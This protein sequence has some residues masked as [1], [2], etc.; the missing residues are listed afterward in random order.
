MKKIRMRKWFVRLTGLMAVMLALLAGETVAGA[1]GQN[2]E[3]SELM[4][5]NRCTLKAEDGTFPDWVEL[6]NSSSEEVSLEGLKLTDR[7]NGKNV[8]AFPD[9]RIPPQGRLIVF[10]DGVESSAKELHMPFK[11]S[12]D[13]SIFLLSPDGEVLDELSTAGVQKDASVC[14]DNG[15]IRMSNYPT[16]GFENTADGF[17]AFQE[18]YQ[19]D[20]PLQINEVRV[21]D[22][23]NYYVETEAHYD[24]V[25]LINVSDQPVRMSDYYLSDDQDLLWQYQ[26]PD[27]VL[28]P[29]GITVILCTKEN[30][31]IKPYTGFALNAARERLFLSSARGVEDY[32][33]LHDIPYDA[34]YGRLPGENGFFYL[35]EPTQGQANRGRAGRTVSTPPHAETE[36]GVFDGTLP[37]PLVLGGEGTIYYTTDGSYPTEKSDVYTGPIPVEKTMIVRAVAVQGD[38]LPSAPVT[39]SYFV[40]EHHSLPVISIVSN[41]PRTL[42]DIVN[43]GQKYVEVPGSIAL[44]ENGEPQ[45]RA[46]CGVKVSGQ[47]SRVVF[48][49]RNIKVEFRSV[50][51]NPTLD[52]DLFGTGFKG[53]DS[54]VLR[55][56]QDSAF[57]LFSNEIWQDLCLEMSD[58]VLTQHGKFCIVYLNGSYYGIYALKEN[59]S[60]QYYAD[61]AGVDPITVESEI[62][63]DNNSSDYLEMYDLIRNGDMSD[64]E[65]Y[66]RA[67]RMLD[68]DSFID[69]SIMEGLCG[70]FDLFLNVRFFRSSENGD[71]YQMALF[72]LD[73]SMRNGYAT[74][75]C[76]MFKEGYCGMP[77][78]NATNI[79][80]GL[81]KSPEFRAAFLKR[82]GE[83]YDTALSNERI[84]ERIEHYEQLLQ[85]E[86]ERDRKR[87][88]YSAGKWQQ[89]VDALK[90]MIQEKDWQNFCVDELSTYIQITDEERRMYFD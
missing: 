21:T 59:I 38:N 90:E 41:V 65:Q 77:N 8:Q 76:L 15:V 24:W 78:T 4:P 87:W 35:S 3:I 75:N 16:P 54:F 11:I 31:K 85:P 18:S 37:E 20:S 58:K 29:G 79:I 84:L 53:Y 34:S 61:W 60:K 39:C 13:E 45:F 51:G 9:I 23:S 27:Q 19:S 44:Y 52:Y 1:E 33:S 43:N 73:N 83:V 40:N 5:V 66:A 67:C 86:I 2:I 55:A 12:E 30:P 68:V 42:F 72:D 26:L 50:Y 80:K 74:W 88:D 82:Y 7:R 89:D 81:F 10:A 62:P 25:E 63:H 48:P 57:R 64:P 47:S 17:I 6:Y 22:Y 69:W 32:V 71:R 46:N 36:D 56:G 14:K 70:N 28:S 49:K